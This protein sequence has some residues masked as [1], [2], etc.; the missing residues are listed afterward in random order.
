MELLEQ[1]REIGA[2]IEPVGEGAVMAARQQLLREIAR[3]ERS[4]PSHRGARRRWIGG[5]A[6]VGGIAAAALVIGVVVNPA[7]VPTAAASVVLEH[8]AEA[9]L[10]TVALSPAPGQ[11][12][13]IEETFEQLH[14]GFAPKEGLEYEVRYTT[15]Y[16]RVIY[17]PSDRSDD[18]VAHFKPVRVTVTDGDTGLTDDIEVAEGVGTE[19]ALAGVAPIEAYP[20]GRIMAGDGWETHEYRINQME[21][22]YDEMPRE[23][24]RLLDWIGRYEQEEG[25]A[26]PALVNLYGFNLAPAD[27]R[28][29]IFRALA[30][31]EG[32]SVISVDGDITTIAY[33]EGGEDDLRAVISVDTALGLIVGFGHEVTD[34]DGA[35]RVG[36]NFGRLTISIA[37]SAPEA[38]RID[39]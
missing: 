4:A 12:I 8:A 19:K 7:S 11:Y 10:A 33:P 9:T 6:L 30:L 32:A 5:S 18:W 14:S 38:V 22:Y 13:R 31:L 15:E 34:E 29:T 3:E 1:V 23:P 37:D 17:V 25:I 16:S 28:A 39:G 21:R 27:L 35:T 20:G 24:Q 36:D 26:A 2:D